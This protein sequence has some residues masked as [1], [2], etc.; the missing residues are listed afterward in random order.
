MQDS[1]EEDEDIQPFA[2]LFERLTGGF[3][4]SDGADQTP[5]PGAKAKAGPNHKRQ[6]Q[7]R[8]GNVTDAKSEKGMDDREASDDEPLI[9]VQ[10]RAKAAKTPG[11]TSAKVNLKRNFDEAADEAVG[12]AAAGSAR[13]QTSTDCG[14]EMCADDREVMN[15]FE[16]LVAEMKEMKPSST[17][18]TTFCQWAK[19][20]WA[21]FWCDYH[22]DINDMGQDSR[23]FM[24]DHLPIAP[25]FHGVYLYYQTKVK[26]KKFK[27]FKSLKM[28][29]VW[30]LKF[31]EFKVFKV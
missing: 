4:E 18:E 13:E 9:P 7:N 19:D 6:N 12:A 20:S 22:N 3:A 17:D 30:S 25:S 8:R 14:D 10:K 15:R 16:P 23:W 24:C 21:V 26:F 29:K 1:G 2:K 11:G 5:R 28:F 27:I 31:K